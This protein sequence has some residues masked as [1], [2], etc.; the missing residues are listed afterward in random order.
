[1]QLLEKGSKQ[2]TSSHFQKGDFLNSR[3]LPSG[4]VILIQNVGADAFEIIR[5]PDHKACGLLFV[6]GR[7]R[8]EGTIPEEYAERRDWMRMNRLRIEQ[9]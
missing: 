9:K 2:S 6:E 5:V 8:A 3:R 7:F 1:L 4:P